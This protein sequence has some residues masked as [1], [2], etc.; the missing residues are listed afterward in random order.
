MEWNM[1][2][3]TMLGGELLSLL[4]HLTLTRQNLQGQKVILYLSGVTSEEP[5]GG[6][7]PLWGKVQAS[8]YKDNKIHTGWL[9]SRIAMRVRA[10]RPPWYL[11]VVGGALYKA[12]TS[13]A[14]LVSEY[15]GYL[16]KGKSLLRF[17]I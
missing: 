1:V 4:P 13:S 6:F 15:V 11:S 9:D 12:S 10:E 17:T 5:D 7:K 16:E 14:A 8:D 2:E 3:D